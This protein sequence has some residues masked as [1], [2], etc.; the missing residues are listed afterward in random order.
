[1]FQAIA[2]YLAISDPLAVSLI[3]RM[4]SDSYEERESATKELYRMRRRPVLL[5][6]AAAKGHRDPE[7]RRRAERVLRRYCGAVKP[8]EGENWPWI[9]CLPGSLPCRKEAIEA[10]H[11][12]IGCKGYAE[13]S[14]TEEAAYRSATKDFLHGLLRKG[15]RPSDVRKLLTDMQT[16][17]KLWESSGGRYISPL[18]W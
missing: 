15:W 3:E 10:A 11:K 6:D 7:V 13:D 4:G 2:L 9:E 17:Q 16:N 1:M 18:D 5:L 14:G 12:S 8:A